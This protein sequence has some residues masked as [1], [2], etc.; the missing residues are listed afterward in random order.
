LMGIQ[1]WG[2]RGL[3]EN[4]EHKEEDVV[5]AVEEQLTSKQ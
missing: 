1:W 5:A 3:R 2:A 4:G